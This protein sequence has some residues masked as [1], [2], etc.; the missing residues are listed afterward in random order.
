MNIF[1]ALNCSYGACIFS[2]EYSPKIRVEDSA[3]RNIF[4]TFLLVGFSPNYKG[5][6]C[7]VRGAK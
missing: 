7:N 6:L 2:F 5:D 1:V 3:L 4:T